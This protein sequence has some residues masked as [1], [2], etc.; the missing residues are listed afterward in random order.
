MKKQIRELKFELNENKKF[1]KDSCEDMERLRIRE[2]YLMNDDQ[3]PETATAL[4]LQTS[5]LGHDY[6]NDDS[7]NINIET[8]SNQYD[9]TTSDISNY[10]V[11]DEF[12]SASGWGSGSHRAL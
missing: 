5:K 12:R 1:H 8:Y 9:K 10:T 7:S 3:D 2:T 6:Y 11:K 4:M